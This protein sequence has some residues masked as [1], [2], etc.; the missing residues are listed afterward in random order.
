MKQAERNA[1]TIL[2]QCTN[3]MTGMM[4]NNPA[5]L[6]RKAELLDMQYKASHWLF[7]GVCALLDE[8]FEDAQDEFVKAYDRLTI[9]S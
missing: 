3:R 9:D 4:P 1:L 8:K 2:Y 5:N 7:R 6:K